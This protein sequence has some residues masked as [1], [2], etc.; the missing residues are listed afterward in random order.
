MINFNLLLDVDAKS[1]W[2]VGIVVFTRMNIRCTVALPHRLLVFLRHN[3]SCA[4]CSF[5][6]WRGDLIDLV[7]VN[8]DITRASVKL[9]LR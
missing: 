6:I 3:Q 5:P 2:F 7:Q 9:R 4:R 8:G 1:M